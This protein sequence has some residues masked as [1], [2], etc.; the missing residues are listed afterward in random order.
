MK[1]V[2][3]F[4]MGA[5]LLSFTASAVAQED[6]K[7]TIEAI[8]KVIKSN[9]A[10][11]E[12]QVKDVV[13][14]NKKNA[15]VIV[16]IAQAY[17]DIKDTANAA[18]YAN[19]ALEKNKKYA[20]AYILLGDIQALSND[21]GSAA[22]LY[23]QAIYFDPKNPEPYR[24]YAS[25]YRKVS[26]TGAVAKLEELRIQRPDISV[27]AMAGHIYVLS[28]NF[29]KAIECYSK[30]WNEDKSK[31]EKS[32]INDYALSL[33][34]LQK[35]QQSLDVVKYG[36]SK[37]P[38]NETYNRLAL[39]DCTELKDYDTALSYADALFNKSDSAK[40]SYRD[41]TY[42]G[43]AYAGKKDY[44]K[45]IEMY[46]KALTMDIDNK[47]KRAG[48]VKQMS[49]AY[50]QM[51]DYDNAI[52]YYE[53]YLNDVEKASAADKAGLASLYEIKASKQTD[54][55][56]QLADFKKAEQIYVQLENDYPD[57]QEYAVFKRARVNSYMD[58]DSKQGLAKP[59]Y[60]K[61][62]SIIEAY[63]EKSNSDKAR[64]IE[65]YSYLG[66]YY[67]IVKDSKSEA[68]VY[69]NKILEVDP[70]NEKA[71]LALGKK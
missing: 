54:A 13:K 10:D 68:D 17:Y 56:A 41:Y 21:G 37:E 34:I 67:L 64:L 71:K 49:D 35:Y 52:K 51:D 14:K 1:T 62:A 28:N 46:Q 18:R 48:V 24:K 15:E 23:E 42:Y 44:N 5:M 27:D 40:L 36:L 22:Q 47:A 43:N 45:A 65:A 29:D 59:I 19:L 3:Y 30:A 16:G 4:I 38:R 9:P 32:D 39:F 55:A 58:P 7:A 53:D 12:D 50:K 11:L 60:E 63:P 33:Y 20:P 31:F 70:T 6:S 25:V 26:P 2:K 57:A 61:L 69:W 66:S 8:T